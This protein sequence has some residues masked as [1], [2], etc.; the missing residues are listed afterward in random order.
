MAEILAPGSSAIFIRVN[1]ALSESVV[2]E[3]K[4]FH[5]KLLRTSLCIKDEEGLSDAFGESG[6]FK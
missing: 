4:K 2:E 5:G 3:F 6:V 1:K